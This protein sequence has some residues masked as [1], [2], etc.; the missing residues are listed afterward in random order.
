MTRRSLGRRGASGAYASFRRPCARPRPWLAGLAPCALGTPYAESLTG[1]LQRLGNAV[2]I[3]PGALLREL[4]SA[5][6]LPES[7]LARPRAMDGARAHAE[8][9]VAWLASVTGLSDLRRCTLLGFTELGGLSADGLLVQHKRW[10]TPCWYEDA[11]RYERTLWNLSVVDACPVH[12]VLLMDRC[13]ECG[14]RQPAV[15]RDVRIGV[16]ALCG[17]SLLGDP[18]DLLERR[19]GFPSGGPAPPAKPRSGDAFQRLWFAGQAAHF[20][21]ALDVAELLGLDAASMAQAR[22]DGLRA[23]VESLESSPHYASLAPK[24]DGWIARDTRPT[25]DALFSVLWRAQWPVIE[26]F[27]SAVRSIVEAKPL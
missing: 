3:P 1:Y 13:F 25:L 18:I 23:L 2:L 7:F 15:S 17:G 5:A 24:I 20:I 6:V 12:S 11:D 9:S 22:R 27:P 14:R 10:C 8:S 26:L 4:Q 21:H 19:V 16:C